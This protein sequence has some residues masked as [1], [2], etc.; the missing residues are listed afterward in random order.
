MKVRLP[1][2]IMSG[3]WSIG[4]MG[5]VSKGIGGQRA[6][7]AVAMRVSVRANV[8]GTIQVFHHVD[9]ILRGWLR[10]CVEDR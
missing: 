2:G 1:E 8:P 3:R 6:M 4:A 10:R 9:A 7:M 5:I